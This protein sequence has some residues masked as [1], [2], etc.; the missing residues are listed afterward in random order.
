ML[1]IKTLII[2]TACSM[3]SGK[4]YVQTL[5]QRSIETKATSQTLTNRE[6][7]VGGIKKWD[8]N[9]RIAPPKSSINSFVIKNQMH[10]F[11][12]HDT[13]RIESNVYMLLLKRILSA[14]GSSIC[15]SG[16]SCP[17]FLAT[18][19]SSKSVSIAAVKNINPKPHK[20]CIKK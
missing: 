2:K 9:Q 10:A 18:N 20:F 19:P 16:D 6:R 4:L 12:C 14:I 13:S 5:L 1:E 8:V 7:I 15:P 11:A 17:N 3:K